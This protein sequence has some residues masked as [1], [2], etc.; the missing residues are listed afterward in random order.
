MNQIE[1]L[2]LLRVSYDSVKFPIL[3]QANFKLLIKYTDNCNNSVAT[4]ST[5]YKIQSKGKRKTCKHREAARQSL[6]N[7][8]KQTN[9]INTFQVIKKEQ[10]VVTRSMCLLHCLAAV[11]GQR[12]SS[13]EPGFYLESKMNELSV[14]SFLFLTV[15]ILIFAIILH[16]SVL[17]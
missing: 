7:Y 11:H 15:C 13:P 2:Q 1:R 12:L 8:K 16:K 14:R 4:F 17:K 6:E 5:S 10:C 3:T 9:K